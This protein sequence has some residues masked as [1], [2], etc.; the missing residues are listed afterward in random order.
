MAYTL[1]DIRGIQSQIRGGNSADDRTFTWSNPTTGQNELVYGAQYTPKINAQATPDGSGFVDSLSGRALQMD[2]DTGAYSWAGSEGSGTPLAENF[3]LPQS[4]YQALQQSPLEGFNLQASGLPTP[5][6]GFAPE[7][8]FSG[9][10]GGAFEKI[11]PLVAAATIMGPGAQELLG[12]LTNAVGG[13][14]AAGSSTAGMGAA[15]L[16]G[17]IPTAA[18]AGGMAS[19][20][21]AAA[22]MVSGMP[23][24]SAGAAELGIP[25]VPIPGVEELS[26]VTQVPQM[27]AGA[28][29]ATGAVNA[30]QS[31]MGK[32]PPGSTS[33]VQ[34]A[35][36]KLGVWNSANGSLGPNALPLAGMGLSAVAQAGKGN[37]LQKSLTEAA[38]PASNAA[39]QLLS[40]GLSGQVPEAFM[41]QLE[42]SY[43]EKIQEISQRYANM[44]RDATTDSAAQYEMQRAK[45]ARDAQVAQYASQLTSQGLQA[46]SIAQGPTMQAA[47]AGAQAD[48]SLQS[49]IAS[50]L[51]QMA[52]LEALSK[53]AA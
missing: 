4:Y 21:Q 16:A 45:D 28:G 11:A 20:V 22:P 46:A 32:L 34:Q 8:M 50:T 17:S 38:G 23:I 27:A 49:A 37:A 39:Q 25:G 51:Q 3:F 41:T 2:P 10:L 36:Q 13:A 15:D 30:V 1:D 29:G 42:R 43:Q 12:Y 24:G 5:M 33:A 47:M 52:M 6:E 44:G 7:G 31:A 18:Q 26:A 40:Q 9:G 19:G 14:T 53:R 35:L 48:Q